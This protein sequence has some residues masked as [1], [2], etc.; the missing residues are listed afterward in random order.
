MSK[1]RNTSQKDERHLRTK[2]NAVK[3]Y[4]NRRLV[5]AMFAAYLMIKINQKVFNMANQIR[6]DIPAQRAGRTPPRQPDYPDEVSDSQI[7]AIKKLTEQENEGSE[8]RELLYS[9]AW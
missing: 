6:K 9:P 7:E 5:I 3:R 2:R 1:Q 4:I 8:E